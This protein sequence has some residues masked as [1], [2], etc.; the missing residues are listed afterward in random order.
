MVSEQ[1]VIVLSIMIFFIGLGV[2]AYDFWRGWQAWQHN[3]YP[4]SLGDHLA[5]GLTWLLAGERI[6]KR[7]K[8]RLHSPEMIRWMGLWTM[9]M[10]TVI[11]LALLVMILFFLVALY[12]L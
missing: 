9:I 12:Q 10:A 11:G 7:R 8:A 1:M 4:H 3:R 5:T 2:A 6:A